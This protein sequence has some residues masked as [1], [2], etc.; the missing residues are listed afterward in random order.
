MRV[1][2]VLY[3]DNHLLVVNKPP[4]MLVQKDRSGNKCVLDLMKVFIARRDAKSGNVFMG[5]PHRLDR[6]I[7][8][9]LVLAK[10][11]KALSRLSASFRERKATKIY[12]AVVCNSPDE[13]S[14]ALVDWLKKDVRTNISRRVKAGSAG[15]KEA[16]LRYCVLA[17]RKRYWLLEVE[18]YT[19]RHH[20]IRAQ[21][22]AKGCPIKGDLKYGAKR[23]NRGGGIHLHARRLIIPHP[24]REISVEVTAPL[25][26]D[27]VWKLF[28]TD[29]DGDFS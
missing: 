11:S 17:S 23:S 5:L 28:A 27:S 15:A 16:Q 20:Q 8:G 25:P 24:V 19:G 3:E 21:L 2:V 22:S 12:W 14:G 10:T 18:L 29:F 6:P 1:P 13:N 4:G 26:E 7:S 9:A